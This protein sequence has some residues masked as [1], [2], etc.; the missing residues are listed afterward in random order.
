MQGNYTDIQTKNKRV[1]KIQI[2]TKTENEGTDFEFQCL[3]VQIDRKV[4]YCRHNLC[5]L[6]EHIIQ[7]TSTID[8]QTITTDIQITKIN[9]K[10]RN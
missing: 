8:L 2:T 4:K 10:Q 6:I 5:D 3:R 7:R 1:M 9:E